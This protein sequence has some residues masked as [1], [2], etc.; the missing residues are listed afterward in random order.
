MQ[1]ILILDTMY[2]LH[3]VREKMKSTLKNVYLMFLKI[4]FM[5][6]SNTSV[7]YSF[8]LIVTNLIF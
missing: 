3:E 8:F 1:I 2:S 7:F 4:N 5:E 6:N